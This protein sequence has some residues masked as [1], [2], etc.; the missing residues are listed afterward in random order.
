[1]KERAYG[2]QGEAGQA[3]AVTALQLAIDVFVRLFAP[4]IPFATEEVWSWTHGSDGHSGSVHRAPWPTVDELG[5]DAQHSGLLPLASQALIGI[6]RAKTDAKA[7]QKTPVTS[8]II[9]APS[10]LELA[11][12]DLA[13]VGRIASLTITPADEVTVVEIELGEL[14]QA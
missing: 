11:A 7:S 9:A 1:V 4:V 13:A 5:V 10:L 12:A 2:S 3:S 14:P 8:C 6:R